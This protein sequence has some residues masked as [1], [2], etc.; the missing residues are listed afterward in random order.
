MLLQENIQYPETKLLVKMPEGAAKEFHRENSATGLADSASRGEYAQLADNEI[1]IS[2]STLAPDGGRKHYTWEWDRASRRLRPM[3]RLAEDMFFN[4]CEPSEQSAAIFEACRRIDAN[5]MSHI[6]VSAIAYR[7]PKALPTLRSLH[8]EISRATSFD[9]FR[10]DEREKLTQSAGFHFFCLVYGD[11]KSDSPTGL[12]DTDMLEV[13][14]SIEESGR[15]MKIE[16]AATVSTS[17]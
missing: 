7:G 10:P 4:R 3:N 11:P 1:R 17:P 13:I 2:I 15:T 16:V 5:F 12:T 9:W 6:P 14:E 8:T